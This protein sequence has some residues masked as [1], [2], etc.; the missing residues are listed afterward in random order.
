MSFFK[1][2]TIKKEAADNISKKQGSIAAR[3]GLS[4]KLIKHPH[5]SE[6]AHNL[7]ENNKYVFVVDVSANKSLVKRE[8]ENKYH[9]SVLSVNMIL[10]KGKIKMWRNKASRREN[11]KKAIIAIKQGQK[12]ETS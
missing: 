5:L 1:K 9:V 11:F 3:K 8:I 12:I 7:M 4:I 2:S 6:K 10:N